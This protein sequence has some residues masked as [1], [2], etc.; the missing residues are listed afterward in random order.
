MKKIIFA[1]SLLIVT[2]ASAD[3]LVGRVVGISDGDTV[4]VLDKNNNQYKVRLAGIDA[5]EKKQAF[6]NA[7]KK[8]LSD[9]IYNQVVTVESH[10]NDRYGRLVGK[11]LLANK[12]INKIQIER[13]M[14]WFYRKY[15][16]ELI[17]D[18]RL[19]YLHAE[20]DAKGNSVGL[21]VDKDPIPPWE[22][23]KK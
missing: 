19:S 1:L 18:D 4:T 12:Y 20:N 10:K 5:P 8:S 9:L 21:W 6:G 22:F 3:Q 13:G 7:S 15:Q 2:S 16:N 11:I 17:L 14:A 23:R